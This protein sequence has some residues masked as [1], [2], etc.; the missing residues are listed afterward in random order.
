MLPGGPGV[1]LGLYS[2]LNRKQK[3]RCS[4]RTLCGDFVRGVLTPDIGPSFVAERTSV[5]GPLGGDGVGD[6]V[7]EDRGESLDGECLREEPSMPRIK[8]RRPDIGS[9]SA[10]CPKS[11]GELDVCRLVVSIMLDF[12]EVRLLPMCDASRDVGGAPLN[13][14]YEPPGAA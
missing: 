8:P 4:G 7:N 11:W 9:A 13:E 3:L 1:S 10:S 12:V 5:A 6:D 14:R 2:R